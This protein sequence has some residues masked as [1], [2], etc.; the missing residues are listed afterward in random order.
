VLP[1]GVS[2]FLP[3]MGM[4]NAQALAATTS[5]AA[6]VC[7]IADTT[8]TIEAGKD[9]DILAV[10]GNPLEDITAIHH[11]VAAYVRGRQPP[12]PD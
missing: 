4:T 12:H 2:S 8:G 1:Y 7:G 6:D 9:A 3:A 5:V 10:A 11:V